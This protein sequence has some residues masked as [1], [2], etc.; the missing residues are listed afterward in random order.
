MDPK[1]RS[2]K[3]INWGTP[4]LFISQSSKKTLLLRVSFRWEGGGGHYVLLSDGP[5]LFHKWNWQEIIFD[6]LISGGWVPQPHRKWNH[7][8]IN[9]LEVTSMVTSLVARRNV[10]ACRCV[11]LLF[12]E[13]TKGKRRWSKEMI[14]IR[15]QQWVLSFFLYCYHRQSCKPFTAANCFQEIMTN[16]TVG[17]LCQ[18]KKL[19]QLWG[20]GK[21]NFGWVRH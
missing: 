5:K 12:Y 7:S 9:F 18:P 20:L 1:K 15:F 16:F 10:P 3:G 17:S 21:K 11:F 2:S 8:K 14:S 13:K 4:G 6:D 19:F